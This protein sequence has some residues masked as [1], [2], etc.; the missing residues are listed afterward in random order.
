VRG[1]EEGDSAAAEGGLD[2]LGCM[3]KLT[4]AP[5]RRAI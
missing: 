1:L 4:P 5:R 3:M 2:L